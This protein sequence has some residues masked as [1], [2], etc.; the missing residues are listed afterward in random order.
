[1]PR[2]LE[3]SQLYSEE[4]GIDLAKQSDAEYS[5]RSWR[6]CLFGGRISET[7]AKIPIEAS[8]GMV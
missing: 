2:T 3:R 4:L 7:I 5:D 1:M 6:A 8:S